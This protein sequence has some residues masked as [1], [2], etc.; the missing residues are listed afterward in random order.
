LQGQLNL[1]PKIDISMNA[2]TSNN[3]TTPGGKK[4]YIKPTLKKIG[5]V[6]KLTLK[7]GSQADAFSNF[8]A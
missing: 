6:A 3:A 1:S 2:Y 8:S 5:S 7:G 4:S